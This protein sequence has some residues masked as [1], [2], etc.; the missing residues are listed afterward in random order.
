[1]KPIIQVE[2]G[3][4]DQPTREA[5]CEAGYLVV[6]VPEGKALTIAVPMMV[7]PEVLIS[8][9]EMSVL[10]LEAIA[11]VNI[12]HNSVA[13]NKF[14]EG[15]AKAARKNLTRRQTKDVPA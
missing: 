4:V 8:A 12:T 5:M 9:D 3:W 10:A 14:V 15:M 1:M 6:E 11:A 13:Y 7:V 2:P